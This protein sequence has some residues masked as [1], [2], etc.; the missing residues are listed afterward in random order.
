MPWGL[1]GMA[2][3]V[4]R[5]FASGSGGVMKHVRAGNK[6]QLLDVQLV[7]GVAL[8]DSVIPQA[9]YRFIRAYIRAG[10]DRS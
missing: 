10:T 9:R 7:R 5:R 3:L 6:I 8:K 1:T 2:P 4:S